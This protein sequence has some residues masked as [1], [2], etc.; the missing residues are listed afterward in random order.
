[1]ALA[2]FLVILSG[3]VFLFFRYQ[4]NQ[5]RENKYAE[6]S[7]IARLKSDE[8]V[9]WLNERYSD[10]DYFS[11]SG[12]LKSIIRKAEKGTNDTTLQKEFNLL[13]KRMK[14]NHH[15]ADISVADLNGH[16]LYSFDGPHLH[17]DSGI[18]SIVSS[19][20]KSQ[21]ILLHDFSLS[22]DSQLIHLDIAA[23]VQIDNKNR[24][25]LIFTIDPHTFLYP[26][27]QSWPTPSKTSET[28]LL[29][30]EG[31]SVLYLNQLKHAPWAALRLR[32]LLTD[33]SVPP[34][35][36]VS[37]KLESFKGEDY[38]GRQVIADIRAIHGTPW[39]MVAKIDKSEVFSELTFRIVLQALMV[40]LLLLFITALA[41]FLY[42]RRQKDF[43]E[44]LFLREQEFRMA[45][46]EFRIT[47]YSIGDAVIITN[48]EGNIRHMNMAAEKLT[49][50]KESE[51]SGRHF[52]EVFAIVHEKS[53]E[54][55][56]NPIKRVLQEGILADQFNSTLLVAKDGRKIPVSESGAIVYDQNN[57]ISGVVL[58]F[59]DITS[60]K[61]A[62][63]EITK[64]N[65]E[66]EK[67][68]EDRTEQL[69]KTNKELE[70]FTY[71][72]SHDLR[73]P[74]RAIDGFSAMLELDYKNSLDAE[75]NRLIHIIRQNAQKMGMLIDQLLTFSRLGRASMTLSMIDMR[76]MA[77][78]VIKEL[79]V[80]DKEKNL[81]INVDDLHPANGDPGM[82][83]QV[84]INLISNALKFTQG[85]ATIK[86]SISS[87]KKAG[88]TNYCIQDNGAGFD[89]KY[90]DKLFG[91]FQRLHS[92]KQFGGTGVGL[93]I[94]QQVITRHGGTIWADGKINQG[95]IFCF[96]LPDE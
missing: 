50:W 69:K 56:D 61:D 14:E 87:Y 7:A 81:E 17:A 72:V 96:S 83:R 18:M 40:L 28:L 31:D 39:L 82:L 77:D 47:L 85:K 8:I 84:W 15:Y 74:L 76:E 42:S 25:I 34:Q 78:S 35:D 36:A 51:A 23:P 5:I 2:F 73:T 65:E 44:K 16:L 32:Q 92:E 53:R 37:G 38:A 91:V 68:V 93:A 30:K 26:L 60:R 57:R 71:S 41:A 63:A 22:P 90:Y 19:V 88:F 29:R 48:P 33:K 70:A 43:Y 58:V 55:P 86:I 66:L 49:G 20:Q 6:I 54:S 95:A 13:F 62:E 79:T 11:R 89:M 12:E 24:L 27:V 59:H 3:G 46:E 45:Q 4:V 10:A 75:G 52:E 80:A 21:K 67:R 1:M 9:R 94:V 64:L